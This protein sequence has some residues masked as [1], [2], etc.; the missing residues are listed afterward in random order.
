MDAPEKRTRKFGVLH[1]IFQ[2]APPSLILVALFWNESG[3][4]LVFVLGFFIIPVLVSLVSILL[5]LF[6][7]RNRKYF[8]LASS[9]LRS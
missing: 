7:L 9:P 2:V 1:W 3:P 8:M 6:D 5:K 4:G